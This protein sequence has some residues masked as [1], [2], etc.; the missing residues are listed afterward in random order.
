MKIKVVDV[1]LSRPIETIKGLEGYRTLQALVRLHGIPIGYTRV[2]VTDGLCQAHRL[3]EAILGE[4]GQAIMHHLLNDGLPTP[5]DKGKLCLRDLIGTQHP[6]YDGPQPLVTVAVC[7][8]DRPSHLTQCLDS[9]NDLN[10]PALDLLLVDNAPSTEATRLLVSRDYPK[11][12]YVLEPR[13]GLDSAR[14]RV[15]QEARGEIVAYTDDDVV[16]DPGWVTAL[17]PLFVRDPDVM[18]VTGLV[19][20]Y[21]LETEAQVL[22]ERRGGFGRG[23]MQRIYG[24]E[25]QGRLWVARRH[26]RT[27]EMGT[28]ANMAFRKDLFARIGGFDTALDVGTVTKAGGDLEMFFRVLKSDS[29]LVYE[30]SVMVRHRHR[31]DHAQLRDQLSGWEIGYG[32]YLI[33]SF[34]FYPDARVV[35]VE[36]F[37]RAVTWH[38]L[39]L[40]FS[41][42]NVKSFP[43]GLIFAEL[44]GLL[45]SLWRYPKACSIAAEVERTYD[46]PPL[47][48]SRQGE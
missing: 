16:V 48:R 2:P 27:F 35:F 38:C 22:F 19:V 21:E 8:R 7:T 41:F 26:A 15:I 32:A 11:I 20:P 4:H 30:P 10:Y 24:K 43:K 9:L 13:P 40:I 12:R 36:L 34:R 14:N 1:E 44:G 31:S 25:R 3:S 45:S 29:K 42:L 6:R 28:G 5:T 39:R 33:R 47:M 23:F 37:L 46:P 18:A 17:V